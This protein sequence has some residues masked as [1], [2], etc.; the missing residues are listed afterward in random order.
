MGLESSRMNLVRSLQ[1]WRKK[2]AIL[3]AVVAEHPAQDSV[4]L[5]DGLSDLVLE[6]R[7]RLED[8]LSESEPLQ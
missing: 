6:V 3:D 8:A 5:I 1:E 7:G 4:A 2:L